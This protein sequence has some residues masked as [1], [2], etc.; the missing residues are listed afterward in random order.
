MYAARTAWAR[1]AAA[2]PSTREASD[3]PCA[4]CNYGNTPPD[5]PTSKAH[6][7]TAEQHGPASTLPPSA[8]RC[9]TGSIYDRATK[10]SSATAPVSGA[11]SCDTP[12]AESHSASRPASAPHAASPLALPPY[13]PL[14]STPGPTP[15]EPRKY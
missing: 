6:H 14:P 1:A 11:E 5:F 10:Y 7:E 2:S 3:C 9:N 15:D 12:A 13:A 8:Q 4:D